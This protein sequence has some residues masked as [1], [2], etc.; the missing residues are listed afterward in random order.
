V[1]DVDF[2]A[3]VYVRQLAAVRRRLYLHSLA[4]A[5]VALGAGMLLARRITRPVGELAMAAR[6]VVEGDF[7]APV[8][9]RTSD[10]IGLLGN[11]FHLMVDRV[12]VSH[13]NLVDVLVRALEAREGT[14]GSLRRLARAALAMAER[15]SLTEVQRES[16]ELG[17]LLHDIGEIRTPERL[18]QTPG[19]LSPEDRLIVARHPRAGIEIL[20]TVPLLT[21]ALDVVGGHH[22]RWDGSGYPQGLK[23][24]EI[25]FIARVF[26]VVDALDAMTHAR[27]YRD[28]MPIAS[29]LDV[30]RRE[31]GQ[32]FDPQAVEAALAL[33]AER[34][35][36]LLDLEPFETVS[37]RTA[38]A[39]ARVEETEAP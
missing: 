26:S 35:V 22:E 39:G 3:D 15:L 28:A 1:L 21:P 9:P 25:P 33:P 7:S 10:E 11:V 31:A 6:R 29:A 12:R 20:E 32:Q 17:A 5:V 16:L 2:R 37:P 34:W 18:L 38:E 4:A 23:G 24:E 13:R 19:P 8:H 30:L 14:P 27:P 36:T